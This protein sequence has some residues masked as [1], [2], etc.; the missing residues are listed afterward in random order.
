MSNDAR[1]AIASETRTGRPWPLASGCFAAAG[2]R[3]GP[4][5]A[6]RR[7]G[8]KPPNYTA[9]RARRPGDAP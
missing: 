1:L 6:S 5:S 9:A 2:L 8:R 7:L 4:I 3:A